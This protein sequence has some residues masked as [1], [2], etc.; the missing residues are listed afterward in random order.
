MFDLDEDGFIT[1]EEMSSIVEAIDAMLGN[2]T[3]QSIDPKDANNEEGKPAQSSTIQIESSK[4]RID[5]IFLKLDRVS[6]SFKLKVNI[7]LN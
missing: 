7:V 4:E 3:S 6:A 1:R 5:K 2:A